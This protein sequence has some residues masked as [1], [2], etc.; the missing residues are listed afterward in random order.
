[1]GN[2]DE[3][4]FKDIFSSDEDTTTQTFDDILKNNENE[5]NN[6]LTF[7]NLFNQATKYQDEEITDTTL[8]I[9]YDNFNSF[10][11]ESS[12]PSEEFS[13]KIDD[14]STLLKQILVQQ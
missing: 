14:T 4:T 11:E 1:M 13:E 7:D 8:D 10:E 2:N 6:S 5:E 3:K 9:S 12:L